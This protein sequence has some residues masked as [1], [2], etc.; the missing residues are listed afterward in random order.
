MP[1]E[2]RGRNITELFNEWVNLTISS[3]FLIA[4]ITIEE[5][6]IG[7][8]YNIGLMCN[9]LVLG[10]IFIN[11]FFVFANMVKDARLNFLRS[12]NLKIEKIMY[13]KLRDESK[14]R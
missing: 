7:K 3:W 11:A 6:D 13:K 8:L 2:H 4:M 5:N 10:M 9:Y 14:Q 12:K 1:F